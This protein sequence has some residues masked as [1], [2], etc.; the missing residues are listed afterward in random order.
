MDR[1]TSF[2]RTWC[3]ASRS[4]FLFVDVVVVFPG[5][6]HSKRTRLRSVFPEGERHGVGFFL[7][8]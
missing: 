8:P 2:D 7:L 5:V 4:V 3:S 6:N 1:G